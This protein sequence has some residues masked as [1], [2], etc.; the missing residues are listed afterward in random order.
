M[1]AP[2]H[3]SITITLRYIPPSAGSACITL[4]HSNAFMLYFASFTTSLRFR[5]FRTKTT[6]A[7]LLQLRTS[8]LRP[9]HLHILTPTTPPHVY[10]RYLCILPRRIT[11]TYHNQHHIRYV[12]LTI[13]YIR[14]SD[15]LHKTKSEANSGLA[16]AACFTFFDIKYAFSWSDQVAK[17]PIASL[18][19]LPVLASILSI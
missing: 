13:H 7:T 6:A 15:I 2:L 11:Y 17:L 16:C 12:F 4:C 1:R 14:N 18:A 3:D 19:V 10:K 8:T 5:S 9:H